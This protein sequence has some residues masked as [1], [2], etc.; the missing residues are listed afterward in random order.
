MRRSTTLFHN[1]LLSKGM[2]KFFGCITK[3]IIICLIHNVL[4][5][6]YPIFRSLPMYV[7]HQPDS[8]R[9]LSYYFDIILFSLIYLSRS[10]SYSNLVIP[11]PLLFLLPVVFMAVPHLP[12][13]AIEGSM[14]PRAQ[15]R[16][17]LELSP[18]ATPF[19]ASLRILIIYLYRYLILSETHANPS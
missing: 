7:P 5:E 19:I 15:R 10:L 14:W 2:L 8:P 17:P 6:Y 11:F 1:V 12:C 3:I 16:Y 9:M 4:L 18:R 13:S